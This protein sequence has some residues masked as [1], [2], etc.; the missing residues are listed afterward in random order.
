MI[1]NIMNMYGYIYIRNHKYYEADNVYK[2][3]IAKNIPER[4]TQYATG[5]Y[6]RGS[7]INVYE[8]SLKQ[9]LLIERLLQNEFKNLNKRLNGGTEFFDIKILNMIEPYF[10]K[11]GIIYKKLSKEEI[12]NL[13]RENRI[14]NSIKKI[15]KDFLIKSLKFKRTN[16]EISDITPRRDQNIIIEKSFDHFAINDKGMLVL[17]CGVGKTL[18]SIWITKKLNSNTILIGVPNILLLK[19]WEKI[20]C[21]MFEFTPYLLVSSGITEKD[22]YEFIKICKK[23]C[24]IITTYSSSHKIFNSLKNL[25]FSFDM[26]INDEVHHLTSNN[27]KDGESKTFVNMLKIKSKK[28]LSLTATLKILENDENKSDEDII[29]SND[30]IN[31]F[32]NIIDRKCLLWA[33][34]N[35]VICDYLIQT[36]ICNEY[37]LND[38]FL[39]FNII[40]EVDKRLF[41]S[42]YSSLKSISTNQSHHLLIYSNNKDNST[43]IINY[44]N[45]LLEN[46][47]FNLINFYCSS[48]HSEMK[49]NQQKDI[50]MNFE[51]SNFGIVSCVFCLGEGWDFP[52]LDG[53]VFS[54][55]MSSNI[56]IIQSA[57]RASRKNREKPDKITKIIL[58]ILNQEDWL[59]NNDNSDYKKIREV[60]YQMALEDNTVIQKMKVFKINVTSNKNNFNK[61]NNYDIDEFGEFEKELTDKLILKTVRRTSI[62]ISYEKAKNIIQSKKIKNKIEYYECCKKDIRLSEDPEITYKE[63]FRNWIEYLGIKKIYYE[64]EICKKKVNEYI[65]SNRKIKDNSLDISKICNELCKSDDNFPPYGLWAEYYKL[66][67][68]S[69]IIDYNNKKKKKK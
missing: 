33:I 24:I 4:D 8:V 3:G 5:E 59:E 56:R 48:Y 64:I 27:M 63:E 35:N 21:C 68:L 18:I 66:K 32:G 29:V 57:L 39:K 11:I 16:R 15:N 6:V 22:I 36:I 10:K 14:K 51:K 45:N 47:Y 58:P 37:K 46:N 34:N 23:K 20:I 12:N 43:K 41:L 25:D 28:Q 7:F 9:M 30:N 60:I 19:Q 62:N 44:I 61:E 55:N 52:L 53:V 69:Q 67:D 26:K 1:K 17:M 65:L 38:M 50:L 54:E 40:K 49:I 31:Y 13:T 42:A 2:L